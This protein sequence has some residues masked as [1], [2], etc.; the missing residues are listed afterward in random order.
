MFFFLFRG[1]LAPFHREGARAGS[2]RTEA[3]I[4]ERPSR[5][6]RHDRVTLLLVAR[7]VLVETGGVRAGPLQFGAASAGGREEAL[8]GKN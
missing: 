4:L 7:D 2:R 6:G 3:K 5:N 8:T 1:A